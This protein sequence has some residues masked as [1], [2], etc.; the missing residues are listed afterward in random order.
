M[1]ERIGLPFAVR[2]SLIRRAVCSD[3]ARPSEVALPV[4]NARV[5]RSPPNAK[6]YLRQKCLYLGHN[7]T[8]IGVCTHVIARHPEESGVWNLTNV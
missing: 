1:I 2:C 3:A 8:Q 5:R 7:H 4:S 6:L